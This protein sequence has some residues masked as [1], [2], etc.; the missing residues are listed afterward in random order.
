MTQRIG[1]GFSPADEA[2][3]YRIHFWDGRPDEIVSLPESQQRGYVVGYPQAVSAPSADPP[4][5]PA[6]L[7]PSGQFAALLALDPVER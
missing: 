5:L 3:H 7:V 4:R 2:D 1:S 6:P